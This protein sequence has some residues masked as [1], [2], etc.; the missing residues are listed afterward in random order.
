MKKLIMLSAISI[1]TL[2]SFGMKEKHTNKKP[3]Q[4][5]KYWFHCA[6]G[7]GSGSFTCDCDLAGAQSIANF[8]CT[9]L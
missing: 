5:M 9:S 3:V 6:D 7:S 8:A 1:I 4:M 2:S